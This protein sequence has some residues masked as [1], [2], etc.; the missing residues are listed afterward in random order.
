M[1]KKYYPFLKYYSLGWFNK[2]VGQVKFY[3]IYLPRLKVICNFSEQI[4]V[5]LISFI[6][7]TFFCNITIKKFSINILFNCLDLGFLSKIRKIYIFFIILSTIFY[8][9][10]RLGSNECWIRIKKARNISKN[11]EFDFK[12]SQ[13][14]EKL[15]FW[16]N[17]TLAE[18]LFLRFEFKVEFPI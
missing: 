7:S 10:T 18:Y 11:V 16:S 17:S 5:S 3:L 8:L 4:S 2:C 14:P 12:M 9:W 6:H 15:H 1:P 13:K